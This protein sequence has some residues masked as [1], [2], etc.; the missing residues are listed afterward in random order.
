MTL[1]APVTEALAQMSSPG[2]FATRRVLDAED[3][4]VSVRG[5]GPIALPVDTATARRLAGLARPARFGRGTETLLDRRVRDT[6]EIGKR[7]LSIDAARWRRTLEP[8]LARI[9]QDL[10]LPEGSRV[11][12]ELHNLLLY[13]P[14]QFFAPHQDSEK[15]DGMFGSL[16]V[17][18]PSDARGGSLVIEHHDERVTYRGSADRTTLIAFYADCRHEVRPVTSGYRVALT[19]N[20]FLDRAAAVAAPRGPSVDTLTERVRAYFATERPPR[21]GHGP[22]RGTPERLV[23]LL[24]HQYTPKGLAWT[25]LKN[26]DARRAAVLREV[27]ERLDCEI[28]LALADIHESWSCED[29][30]FGRWHRR[31]RRYGW[32]HFRRDEGEED[33][34]DEDRADHTPRVADTPALIELCDSSIELHH[35]LAPSGKQVRRISDAVDDDEVCYTKATVDLEPFKSEHEGYTG[36]AGNTVDRWYHRAAVMLWPRA[37]TFAIRAKAS[38]SWA[39]GEIAKGITRGA[40][41]DARR[42]TEQV[43]PFWKQAAGADGTPSFADRTLGVAAGL[44]DRELAATL[45]EPLSL[46]ALTATTAKRWRAL[47]DRYGV[48]W[49]WSVIQRWIG[50]QNRYA[51]PPSWPAGLSEL[52]RALADA[53]PGQELTR[54]LVRARW[55]DLARTL[56]ALVADAPTAAALRGLRLYARDIVDVLTGAAITGDDEVHETIVTRL[57]A[58]RDYPVEAAIEVLRVA[59]SPGRSARAPR[60]SV[61]RL[62]DDVIGELDRRLSAPARA[63]DDW[64][65]TTPVRCGC[66]LCKELTRFLAARDRRQ[67]DW[68]LAQDRRAHIHQTITARELPV[69]HVTRRT[70]RPYTL[71]LTKT[72]ALFTR[73]AAARKTW[74]ADLAWLRSSARPARPRRSR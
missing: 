37:R 12:A 38:P 46:A 43:R 19:L 60:P 2:T 47:L 39:I 49:C 55:T 4:P 1:L 56:D 69:T 17:L 30:D 27:A 25:H 6:W 61:A 42:L 33:D 72:P 11:R 20:L 3:L 8:Q 73:D 57:T 52:G 74:A 71:V 23:Y 7:Q 63:A 70:G 18:L 10:G 51:A 45:L 66:A 62:R 28:V 41:D 64:S 68:P 5:I 14:G 21:W 16:V 35:W 22:S 15:A 26:G 67:L 9:A 44:A 65:I 40:T 29:E 24:D 54:R 53:A 13:G 58:E 34:E 48:D 50:P 36:N 59:G 31:G 32:E